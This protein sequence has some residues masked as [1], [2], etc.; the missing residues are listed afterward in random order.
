MDIFDKDIFN[1]DIS[2][3]Q[4]YISRLFYLTA[5][6][7]LMDDIHPLEDIDND[8]EETTEEVKDEE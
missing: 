3:E 7:P 4:M 1:T 6:K 5:L 8:E 2:A